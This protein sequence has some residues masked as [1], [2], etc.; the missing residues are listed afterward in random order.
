MEEKQ[1]Q[2]NILLIA[3][4]WNFRGKENKDEYLFLFPRCKK[5]SLSGLFN[6]RA[7]SPVYLKAC[8]CIAAKYI[9]N[10]P[11]DGLR[12]S[13]LHLPCFI[14]EGKNYVMY[15]RKTFILNGYLK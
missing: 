3:E 7:N 8:N 9:T 2:E 1:L 11:D 5:H 4:I 13:K 14:Q 12:I 10:T 6:K 15:S